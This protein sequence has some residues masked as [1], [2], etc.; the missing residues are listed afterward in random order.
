MKSKSQKIE[1]D[2]R[3]DAWAWVVIGLIFGAVMLTLYGPFVWE[4]AHGSL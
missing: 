2:Q 1:P 3:A 4:M